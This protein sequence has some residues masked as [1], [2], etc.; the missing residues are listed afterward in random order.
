MHIQWFQF[1]YN[2]EINFVHLEWFYGRTNNAKDGGLFPR[3]DMEK[4]VN[5]Y[6][7]CTKMMWLAL[8][9]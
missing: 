9:G 7:P 8:R 6:C 3:I 1:S 4:Y 5:Y 2:M